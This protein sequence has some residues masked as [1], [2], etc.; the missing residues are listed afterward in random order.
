MKSQAQLVT[1]DVSLNLFSVLTE[2]VSDNTIRGTDLLEVDA[3]QC[4]IK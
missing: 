4:E 1:S 3:Q 2:H